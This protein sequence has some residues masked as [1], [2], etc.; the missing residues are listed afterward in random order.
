MTTAVV[1]YRDDAKR[2]R[3]AV[4]RLPLRVHMRW[5]GENVNKMA[6]ALGEALLPAFRRAAEVINTFYL[7]LRQLGLVPPDPTLLKHGTVWTS[8]LDGERHRVRGRRGRPQ[9]FHWGRP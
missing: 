9:T 1:P 4:A 8:P 7:D 2:I 6:L 3:L 5:V